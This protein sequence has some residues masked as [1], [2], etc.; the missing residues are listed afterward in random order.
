M[1]LVQLKEVSTECAGQAWHAKPST[2]SLLEAGPAL[3]DESLPRPRSRT[4]MACR[5]VF[6]QKFVEDKKREA[7]SMHF[8]RMLH[9]LN[10]K[11]HPTTEQTLN[12]EWI[13]GFASKAIGS[14]SPAGLGEH[15]QTDATDKFN[16]FAA[17]ALV[18]A[19]QEKSDE[20]CVDCEKDNASL[21]YVSQRLVLWTHA[22][23]G[24]PWTP[25]SNA[26]VRSS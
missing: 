1:T 15:P 6:Q 18:F 19:G 21:A 4:S 20:A 23:S 24:V 26:A 25:S 16:V 17:L 10:P 8:M 13:L 9:K 7:I 12:H 2:S 14:S 5:V 3:G 11:Q 22:S